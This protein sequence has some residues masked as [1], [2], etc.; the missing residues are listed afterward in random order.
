ML[1]S[2]NYSNLF[3]QD[4]SGQDTMLTYKAQDNGLAFYPG[5]KI[6]SRIIRS[7][8]GAQFSYKRLETHSLV[9]DR[10]AKVVV[11]LTGNRLQCLIN[12]DIASISY[13]QKQPQVSNVDI[14]AEII[15]TRMFNNKGDYELWDPKDRWYITEQSLFASVEV[16]YTGQPTNAEK[17]L[18]KPYVDSGSTGVFIEPTADVDYRL[19]RPLTDPPDRELITL[20]KAEQS[21]V[22]SLL[23]APFEEVLTGRR[24]WQVNVTNSLES[25]QFPVVTNSA[26]LNLKQTL[27]RAL[28]NVTPYL[29]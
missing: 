13:I 9:L 10:P 4:A 8:I 24:Q 22:E 1:Q 21:T 26:A 14:S 3:W 11:V 27:D 15:S 12:L 7:K 5:Y 16:D 2:S 19:Y 25:T 20:Y 29:I 6:Q 17:A 18:I 23:T 28:S